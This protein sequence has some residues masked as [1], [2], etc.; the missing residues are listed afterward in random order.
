MESALEQRMQGDVY[1]LLAALEIEQDGELMWPS[2][3]PVE[4]LERPTSGVYAALRGP[5]IEWNSP[6]A[7]GLELDWSS[8]VSV[9]ESRFF[10]PGNSQTPHYHFEQGIGWETETGVFEFTLYLA[11]DADAV[12]GPAQQFRSTLWQWLIGVAVLLLLALLVY[13]R[14]ALRPLNTLA[15]ELAAMEQGEQDRLHGVYP[16]EVTGLVH[17]LNAVLA[18]E[19]ANQ[20]RYRTTLGDLAHSLK[21][22]LAVIRGELETKTNSEVVEA[23]LNRMNDLVSWHLGRATRAGDQV[24]SRRV[25]VAPIVA[26]LIETLHKVHGDRNINANVTI[27]EPMYFFGDAA[28]LMEMLG[29]LLD[30][31]FKWAR[32]EVTIKA[33]AIAGSGRPGLKI[34]ICDDGPGVAENQV[35]QLAERGKR[36]DEQVPGHGLGLAM[37]RDIA[38]SYGGDFMYQ[39]GDN[40]GACF[41]LEIPPR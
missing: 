18:S 3:L 20:Q 6:S 1:A 27:P 5:A 41:V 31:A 28:D 38:S 40:G 8:G 29:N 19:Q 22:P 11:R 14:W 24:T 9:G 21:T 32:R 16:P 25:P 33:V 12:Y 39:H 34:E 4:G 30:N 26:D 13:L 2:S 36:A 7:L 23:Q 35:E 37:V 10:G 15:D 17:N